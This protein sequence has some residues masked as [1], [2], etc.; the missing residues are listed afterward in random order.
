[1]AW[2]MVWCDS[3]VSSIQAFTL[4]DGSYV[5]V[6]LDTKLPCFAWINVSGVVDITKIGYKLATDMVA[7]DQSIV[8]GGNVREIRFI[9]RENSLE[10]TLIGTV[11][12]GQV[13]FTYESTDL[14]RFGFDLHEISGEIRVRDNSIMD[15]EMSGSTPPCTVISKRLGIHDH[16]NTIQCR[17]N[18][19]DENESPIISNTVRNYEVARDTQ[20][21]DVVF[22]VTGMDVDLHDGYVKLTHSISG[23]SGASYFRIDS[24]EGDVYVDGSLGE[25]PS[26]TCDID[27]VVTD[28]GGLT[29]KKTFVIKLVDGTHTQR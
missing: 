25:I 15:F 11:G 5:K 27:V 22:R 17:I 7:V 2:H 6:T 3:I 18:L 12:T 23:G 14:D 24:V 28:T 9:A 21:D 26:D 16:S 8:W 13:G 10:G 20:P 19:T 1:M 4:R 29:C